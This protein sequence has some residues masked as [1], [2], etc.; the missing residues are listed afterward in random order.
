MTIGQSVWAEKAII[1]HV[2]IGDLYYHLNTEDHS[3]VVTWDKYIDTLNYHGLKEAVIPAFVTY[4]AQEYAVTAVDSCAFSMCDSLRTIQIPEGVTRIGNHGFRQSVL[5]ESV[6]IPTSV[7]EI[8]DNAFYMCFG[9][10]S[11]TLGTGLRT[12]GESAFNSCMNVKELIIPD[13]VEHIGHHAFVDWRTATRIVIGSGV[14]YLGERVFQGANALPAFEVADG[15]TIVCTVDG[16]LFNTDKDTLIQFPGA[17]GGTYIVPEQ[18]K[19]IG[20]GSFQGCEHITN[21][22]LPE[23]LTYLGTASFVEC[24]GLKEIV[25][26]NGVTEIPSAFTHCPAL[27]SVTIG[28]AVTEIGMV[29][30]G[31]CTAL[32]AFT[33]HSVTPPTLGMVPFFQVDLSAATLYVPEE[34]LEAYRAAAI[35]N[36]FGTINP[37]SNPGI[38]RTKIDDLYYNI[39]TANHVA[40]VTWD[41][42][43][44]TSNYHGL[45]SITIPESVSFKGK[46]YPVTAI[47]TL[48][49][50]C[51]DSLETLVVA[52][53]VTDI[54]YDA[55]SLCD[56]LKNVSFGSGVKRIENNAFAGCKALEEIILPDNVEF[57]GEVAFRD[58]HK[59]ARVVIGSGVTVMGERPFQGCKILTAFEVSEQNTHYCA[60]DGVLMDREQDTLI[61]YPG[62][63]AG[64]YIVPASITVIGAGAFFT[65]ENLTAITLPEG[66]TSIGV[67]AFD[68]CRG[69]TELV[70]PNGVT[71]I[72]NAFVTCS[73]LKS[74]TIGNAVTSIAMTAFAQCTALETFTCYTVTP[75]VT[76][77]VPFFMVN[78]AA[79]TLY[80]P[81]ESVE[82]YRTANTWKEFGTITGI[83]S[84]GIERTQPSDIRTQKLLQN[85]QLLIR[86]GDRIYTLT[87]SEIR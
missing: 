10:Q 77:T 57:I 84:T 58:C 45:K 16:V 9:L 30:F 75:P 51:C 12:I 11:V 41:R 38:V 52:N 20:D 79:A 18:V 43:D 63:K 32:K 53:S 86:K 1:E 15:N 7:T 73:S 66:L 71:E 8:G 81:A 19:A 14:Q 85:G 60:V 82:A 64:A 26:P 3:A 23:G 67:A 61:N 78:L 68:A 46:D 35:W 6:V 25:L 5:V 22:I 65:C 56:V 55:V 28:D 34:A 59:A 69:L 50:S 47:D 48:A 42:Y 17:K 2:Q 72:P 27:E 4:E 70:I 39:D 54:R 31:Q 36:D 49:L 40:A 29:A 76:G 87:G 62:A 74:V 33:C 37:I 21:I 44:R 13:N 80:V 83:P 24:T